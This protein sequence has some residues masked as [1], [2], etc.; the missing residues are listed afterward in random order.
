[1]H[2]D[3]AALRSVLGALLLLVAFSLP[4][5]A[6]EQSTQDGVYT[7]AQAQRGREVYGSTCITC[8][9][10]SLG[11]IDT[12]PALTGGAFLANWNGVSLADMLDRIKVSMPA[13]N[14]GALSRQK[15]ADVMAF[16]LRANGFPTG[17]R[18]LP[19]Q[20]GFLRMILFIANASREGR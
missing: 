5:A 12:A 4:V 19:R 2:D 10:P 13:D 14:P 17:E 8:H 3:P 15:V 18:E 11:G 16:I 20:A 1:M 7:E 6:Q 9:G